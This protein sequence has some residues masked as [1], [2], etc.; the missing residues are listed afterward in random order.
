MS[1]CVWQVSSNGKAAVFVEKGINGDYCIAS[2]DLTT[3]ASSRWDTSVEETVIPK[4]DNVALAF[5]FA[6]GDPLV[7]VARA[8]NGSHY[9][10]SES[11]IEK[12]MDYMETLPG[13]FSWGLD[14]LPTMGRGMRMA[15]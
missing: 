11:A 7:L 14:V 1:K 4:T 13:E 12:L 6:G 5:F 2:Y 9:Y 10:L 8:C 3:I 15:A